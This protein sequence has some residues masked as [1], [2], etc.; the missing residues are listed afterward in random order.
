MADAPVIPIPIPSAPSG[1]MP[2]QVLTGPPQ[3]GQQMQILLPPPLQEVMQQFPEV[4]KRLG[5]FE[6]K[7]LALESKPA[8]AGHSPTKLVAAFAYLAGFSTMA[9]LVWLWFY[10]AIIF[11]L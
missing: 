8:A 3:P 9:A 6:A 5:M 4:L 1:P 11:R 10:A 7:V 2:G